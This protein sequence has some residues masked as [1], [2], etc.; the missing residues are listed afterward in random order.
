MVLEMLRDQIIK[1]AS[2]LLFLYLISN[3]YTDFKLRTVHLVHLL[4]LLLSI[5]IF[6]PRFYAAN[7]LERSVFIENFQSNIE[8]KISYVI[9]VLIS[10]FYLVLMFAEL[11]K[12]KQLLQENFSN[13]SAFNYRWLWQLTVVISSLFAVSQFK[14]IYTFLGNDIETLNGLRLGLVI[15]LLGFLCWIV[16]KSMYEPALFKGIDSKHTLVSELMKSKERTQVKTDLDI[17]S[18]IQSLQAFMAE[19]EPYLDSSLNLQKLATQLGM[20][21]RELSVLINHNLNQH[22]FDF[23]TSYRINRAI[24]ILENPAHNQL[25]ILEVLYDVGFNSK[26]PFNKA[27]K[28][29]TGKTPTEYRSNI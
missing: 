4:P 27:F 23:I 7:N 28:K 2:P 9:S 13:N 25:T 22:F 26:S 18:Q 29:H 10:T 20:P 19:H 14:Q 16:L 12:Y 8:L 17:E 5:L 6:T 21:S 3:I 15:L 1:L 24:A 11:R